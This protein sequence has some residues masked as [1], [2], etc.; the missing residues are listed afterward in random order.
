MTLP[1]QI[2]LPNSSKIGWLRYP[3][4]INIGDDY[5]PGKGEL[6]FQLRRAEAQRL[7]LTSR[8]VGIALQSALNGQPA[9]TFNAEDEERPLLVRYASSVHVR[10]SLQDIDVRTPNR[11]FVRLGSVADLRRDTGFSE[12]KR[13]DFRRTITVFAEENEAGAAAKTVEDLS[14]YFREQIAP[15]YPGYT[16]VFGGQFQEFN[17]AFDNIVLLFGLGAMCIFLYLSS[18]FVARQPFILMTVFALAGALVGLIANGV[19]TLDYCN[20]RYGGTVWGGS[21]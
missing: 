9:G 18:S 12:I 16:L 5:V 14:A 10:Q 11:D 13:R 3:G 1:R 20:L 7:G 8:D 15:V 19:P 2:L 6:T 21:Q 17:Q 4:L